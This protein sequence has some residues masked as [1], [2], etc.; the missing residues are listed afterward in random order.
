MGKKFDVDKFIEELN[1]IEP[2]STEEMYA[3]SRYREC[4]RC[5]SDTW[6]TLIYSP[7]KKGKSAFIVACN[8]CEHDNEQ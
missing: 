1:E 7:K 5:G 6:D 2:E 3:D 8:E 4:P